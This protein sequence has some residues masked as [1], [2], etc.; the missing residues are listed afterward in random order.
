M[1]L[2]S[3]IEKAMKRAIFVR[4]CLALSVLA[5]CVRPSVETQCIASPQL[6][7]IDSLMWTQPDSA[8]ALLLAFAESPEADSLNEFNGHYFQLLV[9]EL[10]YKNDYEQTNRNDLLEAVA[11]FDTI[12]DAFLS[13]RTHY[14]NGVGCYERD[15]VVEACTEYL[16]ALEVMEEQYDEKELVGQKAQFV[17][18]VYSHLCELF[19]DQYLHEQSIYFGKMAMHYYNKYDNEAWHV[20]WTLD[21]IGMH[22]DM[23]DR[24]DSADYYYTKAMEA[25][26]SPEGLGYRDVS[27]HRAYLLYKT[28]SS[29][30]LPLDQM[31]HILRLSE[32]ENERAA[33]GLTIGE[34][35]FH[36]QNLDSAQ[37]YLESVYDKACNTELRIQAAQWLVDIFTDQGDSAKA[38]QA[39]VFLS[40]FANAG[41]QH[42]KTNATVTELYHIHRQYQ[43]EKANQAKVQAIKAWSVLTFTVLILALPVLFMYFRHLKKRQKLMDSKYSK[44]LEEERRLNPILT[45]ENQEL[46]R[47]KQVD[48]GRS[49]RDRAEYDQLLVEA[50]CCDLRKRFI[51]KEIVTTNKVSFYS[52]LAITEKQKR[53]LA[54]AFERHCPGFATHLALCYP[55]L[56]SRDIT[57]CE[58]ILIGLSEK[59]ISILTQI[60]YS[61]NWRRAKKIKKMME[62]Q[63]IRLS[64][65]DLFFAL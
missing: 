49:K 52:E 21:Q 32:S 58:L 3:A 35:Y 64:L 31:R 45:K 56:R 16:K 6:S 25:L 39:E 42:G 24:L 7:A 20:A 43:S 28:S 41:E 36:E 11:Y 13:A 26:P 60:D 8:F 53:Q 27:A 10:L 47:H 9:S 2:Y 29:A 46:S 62:T 33:R 59:E 15:S 44:S 38:N 23:T 18:L 34:I 63:D 4:L 54:E 65:T 14:I 5:S 61:N 40:Q 1:Y 19:S 17:A 48:D 30:E 12:G 57:F 51:G 55:E 50:I 37:K 22:Y